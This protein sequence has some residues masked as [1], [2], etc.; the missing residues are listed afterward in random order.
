MRYAPIALFVYNRLEHLEKV[1]Q[2]LLN[3]DIA[4]LTD[5]IIF[6][7]GPKDDEDNLKVQQ[8][9]DYL[10]EVKGFASVRIVAS[11]VNI[12]LSSSIV[13]GVEEVLK[14]HES[15]IVLE[16]DIVVSSC[17]LNYMN[18]GLNLYKNEDRVIS[19]HGYVLPLRVEM[20]ET[21][22]LRGA[23]CWGWATWRESW[24]LFNNDASYLLGQVESKGLVKDLGRYYYRLLEDRVVGKNDSW[25]ILWHVSAFLKDKLTLYPGS[26]LVLNIGMDRSGV[27]STTSKVFENDKRKD[28]IILK[29]IEVEA[30]KRIAGEIDDFLFK[31][32]LSFSARLLQLI[33]KVFAY[34]RRVINACK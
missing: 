28:K 23:D 11:D 25:A 5:I 10:R 16:D 7:D 21:F 1:I 14:T 18:D 32:N 15:V 30:N 31:H 13:N 24:S 27:H 26:S 33:D 12:G 6:S 9:R 22:F 2:S 34:A 20:P 19:I 3:N 8:V 17:F 4:A 29:S